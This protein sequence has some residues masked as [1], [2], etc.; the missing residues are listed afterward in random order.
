MGGV[1]IQFDGAAFAVFGGFLVGFGFAQG[2]GSEFSDFVVQL[3]MGFEAERVGWGEVAFEFRD[4]LE[5]GLHGVGGEGADDV[6]G[7]GDHFDAVADHEEIVAGFE[8]HA[9]GVGEAV[10]V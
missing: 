10:V 6:V 7:L 9:E 4:V 8:G 3:S 1:L 2:G 5:G